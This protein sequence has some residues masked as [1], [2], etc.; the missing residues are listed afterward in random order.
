MFNQVSEKLTSITSPIADKSFSYFDNDEEEE[1]EKNDASS[2]PSRSKTNTLD[3]EKINVNANP[4][5]LANASNINRTSTPP[6]PPRRSYSAT[7]SPTRNGN[8]PNKGLQ[9]KTS[10]SALASNGIENASVKL[11]GWF[12]TGS[13]VLSNAFSNINNMINDSSNDSSSSSTS[14]VDKR[15][16]APP[17]INK[18]TSARIQRKLADPNEHVPIMKSSSD[19]GKPIRT[20]SSQPRL[21]KRISMAST[22]SNSSSTA[23][24][25]TKTETAAPAESTPAESKTEIANTTTTTGTPSQAPSSADNS[26]PETN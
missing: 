2:S 17:R 25:T 3:K 8:A 18:T 20:V 14:T 19:R 23:S 9:K 16:S 10:L 26:T 15:A 6:P 7:N 21:R 22:A 5:T 4:T 24:V 13:S 11:S 1:V 12:K